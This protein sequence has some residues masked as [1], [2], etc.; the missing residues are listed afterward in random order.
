[1]GSETFAVGYACFRAEDSL[2]R[3]SARNVPFGLIWVEA[4]APERVGY[5]LT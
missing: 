1:M 4:I 3:W 2:P 5:L